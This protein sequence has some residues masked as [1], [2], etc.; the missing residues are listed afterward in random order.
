MTDEPFTLGTPANVDLS[1]EHVLKFLKDNPAFFT[2]FPDVLNDAPP[3][4]RSLGEGVVDF[5]AFQVRNLQNNT[6]DLEEK[7]HSLIDF[8]R[9]NLSAQAE[10]QET[11]LRI[12]RARDL[13]QLLE[14]IAVDMPSL[15]NLDVVRLVV[16][17]PKIEH[18]NDNEEQFGMWH[19]S[20]VTLV[21]IGTTDAA[22]AYKESRLI[23][24]T[25]DEMDEALEGVFNGAVGLARSVAMLKLDTGELEI[26]TML[27]M[28]A[29]QTGRFSE[30]QGVELLLFLGKILSMYLE[31]Y[32]SELSI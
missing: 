12:V 18:V 21:D 15:F 8:C 13:D 4:E 16:E 10:V 2:R 3:A 24:D 17:A 19:Q 20:G 23:A 30:K 5:Q 31:R 27:A 14:V 29:R 1:D 9:D 26:P 32:L 11:V 22:L 6:K 7:Y 28:G 25:N